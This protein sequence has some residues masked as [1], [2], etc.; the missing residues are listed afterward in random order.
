VGARVKNPVIYAKR[1]GS[2]AYVVNRLVRSVSADVDDLFDLGRSAEQAKERKLE[3]D[4]VD[5][6]DLKRWPAKS[7]PNPPKSSSV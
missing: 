6:E 1:H 5:G 7:S 2:F 4:P 3:I